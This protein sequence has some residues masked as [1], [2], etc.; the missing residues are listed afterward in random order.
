LTILVKKHREFIE[1]HIAF[2]DFKEAFDRVSRRK[3]LEILANDDVPQQ[4]IKNIHNI[5]NREVI[6][7]IIENRVKSS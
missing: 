7:L 5:Y 4:T 1:T 6:S 2:V 3:L